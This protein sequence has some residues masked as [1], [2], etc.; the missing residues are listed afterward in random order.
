[1][2]FGEYS[3]LW[4]EKKK[5]GESFKVQFGEENPNNGKNR[6]S[7][8]TAKLEKEQHC[9]KHIHNSFFFSANF[10]TVAT[11][12]IRNLEILVFLGVNSRKKPPN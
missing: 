7:F 5:I 6:Q 11:K 12:Q 2:I 1:L 3:V 9:S 4:L 8:K 10:R